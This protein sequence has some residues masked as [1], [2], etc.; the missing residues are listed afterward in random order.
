MLERGEALL[1]THHK[2][3]PEHLP[4]LI[5]HGTADDVTSHSASKKFI[6]SI[7]ANDKTHTSYE[8]G[9]HELHNEPDGVKEK[10]IEE[11]ITWVEA[12]LPPSNSARL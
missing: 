2:N 9:F 4:I 7:P 10:F 1:K 11:C 3:W 8:G 5:I 6:D 12:H